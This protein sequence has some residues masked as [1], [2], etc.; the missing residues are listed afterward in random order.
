ML[1][2]LIQV[3]QEVSYG[4][5]VTPRGPSE[6][7]CDPAA[8]INHQQFLKWGSPFFPDIRPGE[9]KHPLLLGSPELLRSFIIIL[10]EKLGQ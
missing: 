5:H 8:W 6:A 3:T 9:T 10:S 2:M 4:F 7:I 1:Y